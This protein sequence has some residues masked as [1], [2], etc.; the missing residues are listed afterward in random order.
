MTFRRQNVWRAS[1]LSL[2]LLF[3][4]VFLSLRQPRVATRRTSAKVGDRFQFGRQGYFCVDPDSK[5]GQLVFNRS[6][7]L[8]DTWAKIEKGQKE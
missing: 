4:R 6:V 3:R 5:S 8:K 7:G 1:L 2:P